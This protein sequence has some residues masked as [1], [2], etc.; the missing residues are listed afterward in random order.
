MIA[1]DTLKQI[2]EAA[3]LAADEPLTVDQFAKLFKRGEIDPAEI[4]EQIRMIA[5]LTRIRDDLAG[6]IGCGCLSIDSCALFNP[7]DELVESL[8]GTNKL[9]TEFEVVG[10]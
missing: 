7:N 4:R 6:C 3:L 9:E 1:E 8:E 5:R 2:I 10:G